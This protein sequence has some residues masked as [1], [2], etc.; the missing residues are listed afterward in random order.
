MYHLLY[1][2]L[3]RAC[4][5]TIDSLYTKCPECIGCYSKR[6]LCCIESEF[7]AYKPMCCN[8]ELEKKNL[9]CILLSGQCSMVHLKTCCKGESQMCCIDSR[10]AMP[11][12]EEVPCMFT[13]LPFCLVYPGCYCCKSLNSVQSASS[14]GK[15]QPK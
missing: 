8:K 3:Y 5:C 15:V 9:C 12:D 13:M 1:R 11:C 4:C 14:A 6:V 2:N 7:I 10:F